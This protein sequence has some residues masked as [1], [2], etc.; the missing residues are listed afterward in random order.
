[1]NL[2]TIDALRYVIISFMCYIPTVSVAGWFEAFAAKKLGDTV[3]ER[4]GFLT[5][6]PWVHFNPWGFLLMFINIAGFGFAAFGNIVPLAPESLKGAYKNLRAALEFFAGPFIHFC[7]MLTAFHVLILGF[8]AIYVG[9]EDGLFI[10]SMP[11]SS[12]H[13]ALSMLFVF[14]F[15]QNF[16]LFIVYSFVSLFRFST[17]LYFPNFK[18]SSLTDSI[19]YIFSFCIIAIT[20]GVAAQALTQNFLFF[21]QTILK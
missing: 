13:L 19:I 17:Y 15:Q 5:L 18:L 16:V 20:L 8:H 7:L 3:P 6:N 1:M 12:L 2:Q 9:I 4:A 11:Q 10:M 14:F 21:L